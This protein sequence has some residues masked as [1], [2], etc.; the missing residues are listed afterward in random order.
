[1]T[2][3]RQRMLEDLQLR[4]YSPATITCS[5]RCVADFAQHFHTAPDHLGPEH[6]RTYQLF[7]VREKHASWSAVTQTVCALRFFYRITL[8]QTGMIEYIPQPKRPKTLPT[9]LSQAEVA[10]LLQAPRRLK[11]RAILTTLYAAGLRVSELCHL[12]VKDVESARMVLRIRQGKGQQDRCV[13]L[14]PKL[15]PLLRQYWQQYR[16][17]LWLFPGLDP[18]RRLD[19]RNVYAVCREAGRKAQ[20]PQVIHPHLLRH[21]FATHLLEAGVDLRRIQLLL[22]H[23]NLRTTSRYLHVTPQALSRI[24][25]PL[26]TLPLAP[27][28]EGQL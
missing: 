23:Q 20:L 13:M 11:T 14:S 17:S 5:L 25:S 1:M 10:A 24:P 18:T 26:D 9:I 28:Q 16:P 8:G 15:L 6:I 19:R 27:T 3:L 12:Q 7:L 4:N 2:A 22:G 21:A